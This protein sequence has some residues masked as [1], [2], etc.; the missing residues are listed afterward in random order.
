MSETVSLLEDHDAAL[1]RAGLALRAGGV[2]VI[3]TDTVYGV[4]ADAFN[5][6]ATARIFEIK[7]RPRSLPLPVLVSRPR[8]AWAMCAFVPQAAAELAAAFWPGPLTLVLPQTADLAWD[9][10]DAD[11]TLALRMPAHDDVIALLEMVGPLAATSANVS[12][13]PTPATVAE[14]EQ[15]LGDEIA[16]Y[17]DGGPAKLDVGSTIVDFT[18]N[19]IRLLR[20]GPISVEEVERVTGEKVK[21]A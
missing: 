3:P 13:E 16:L 20:E 5:T 4:A 10:G 1:Q 12:G 7:K 9:L 2:V 6:V 18:R 19:K 21:R 17:V 8:Q 15:H 14:I 11:G